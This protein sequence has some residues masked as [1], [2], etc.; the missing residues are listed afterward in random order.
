MNVLKYQYFALERLLVINFY[1]VDIRDQKISL[2]YTDLTL[3]F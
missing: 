2:V 1:F 3:Y